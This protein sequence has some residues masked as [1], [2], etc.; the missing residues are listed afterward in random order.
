MLMRNF[1]LLRLLSISILLFSCQE[2]YQ[3]DTVIG[4]WQLIETLADPGNGSGT[5]QPYE[6]DQVA[7]F[8]SDST[9]TFSEPFCLSQSGMDGKSGTYDLDSIYL[10]DCEFQFHYQ[11]Q[12][13]QLFIYPPCIE[14]CG[15]KFEKIS[16]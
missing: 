10:P 2:T 13:D 6:G 11:L 8:S 16:D 4:K 12:D 5:Y 3:T 1:N 7:T 14:P 9:I 15:L